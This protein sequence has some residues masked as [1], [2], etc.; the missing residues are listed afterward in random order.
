MNFGDFWLVYNVFLSVVPRISKVLYNYSLGEFFVFLL[1]I[2][3]YIMFIV[4]SP[5]FSRVNRKPKSFGL[6]FGIIFEF[7]P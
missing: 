5:W 6:F 2:K 4:L 1:N 7:W 3:V